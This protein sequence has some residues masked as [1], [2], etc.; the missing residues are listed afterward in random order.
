MIEIIM[1]YDDRDESCDDCYDDDLDDD[2]DD[3]FCKW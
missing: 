3:S 1:I 2:D